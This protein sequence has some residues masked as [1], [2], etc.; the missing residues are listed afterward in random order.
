MRIAIV[1]DAAPPQVNGVVRTLT[2]VTAEL[3]R[4]GH[5]VRLI[6]PAEFLSVPLPRNPE[7]RLVLAPRRK[8]A[9]LI[10]AFEPEAVHIATEGPLG[11]AARAW[12]RRHRYPFTTAYHTRFP[13]YLRA[14][15]G[16]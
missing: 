16:V 4:V 5:R 8:L 3:E 10:A 11:L 12:C 14:R 1:S 6:G 9:R 2:A 13:E 7:I 15:L